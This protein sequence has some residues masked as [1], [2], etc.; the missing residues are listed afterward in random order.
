MLGGLTKF[1]I[2]GEDDSRI[3]RL[4][5]V[6]AVREVENEKDAIALGDQRQRLESLLTALPG[7][8]RIP[9]P[10]AG[11]PAEQ[12]V[13]EVSQRLRI[14]PVSRQRLLEQDGPLSR[15]TALIDILEGLSRTP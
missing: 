14:D 1:R 7:Q 2:T 4:A 5:H 6:V 11:V 8:L 3:Y 9:V 15:A 10:P 12:V 13:D